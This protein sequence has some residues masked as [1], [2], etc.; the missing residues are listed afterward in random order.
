MKKYHNIVLTGGPCAG[1][2]SA[3]SF[4]KTEL[5]TRNFEVIIIPEIAT[6]VLGAGISPSEKFS[7]FE[8]QKII[9]GM[10]LNTENSFVEFAKHYKGEKEIVFLHDRGLIDAKAYMKGEED[11]RKLVNAFGMTEYSIL[12]RYDAVLHLVTAAD[13]AEKFYTKSNNLVRLENVEQAKVVDK[14]TML[15]WEGHSKIWVIKNQ[16]D[17]EQKCQD[18]L[19]AVLFVLGI[20]DSL[21]IERKYRIGAVEAKKIVEEKSAENIEQTY[22]ASVNKNEI[23]RVRKIESEECVMYLHTIKKSIDEKFGNV[24]IEEEISEEEYREYLKRADLK[25]KTIKKTRYYK[26]FGKEHFSVDIYSQP[27]V[28]FALLEI[29]FYSQEKANEFTLPS[30]LANLANLVEVTHD[31]NYANSIIA[32][33]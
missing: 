14:K 3:M 9:F 7:G 12:N 8:F 10:I 11:F 33:M 31:P 16:G 29:E 27:T 22:L 26:F 17:F 28:D 5:E 21:E 32:D 15:S 25:K 13:G 1:K 2:T 19:R 18:T 24:E 6:M 23:E 30:E 20:P 4:L